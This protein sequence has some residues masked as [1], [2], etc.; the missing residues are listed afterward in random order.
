[1]LA[2][3]YEKEM[4]IPLTPVME[5]NFTNST[6]WRVSQERRRCRALKSRA[7]NICD[8]TPL[9]SAP[10]QGAIIGIAG[11]TDS[12]RASTQ[13]HGMQRGRGKRTWVEGGRRKDREGKWAGRGR[14]SGWKR[15][16]QTLYNISFVCSGI[17]PVVFEWHI[18]ECQKK[19]CGNSKAEIC[20]FLC[21]RHEQQFLCMWI[22]KQLL[23]WGGWKDEK[24]WQYGAGVAGNVLLTV[25]GCLC[26][27]FSGLIIKHWP[28]RTL[29]V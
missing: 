7:P 24:A 14:K 2:S 28:T 8:F 9:F 23:L 1:M 18:W 5:Q 29:A 26:G 16:W 12:S 17:Y 27:S 13:G 10:E 20:P 3:E 11:S 15:N 19:Q 21:L 25:F 22:K 4:R 6:G